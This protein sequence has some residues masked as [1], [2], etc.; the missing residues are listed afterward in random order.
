HGKKRP[1]DSNA[2]SSST[3]LNHPSSSRPLDDTI[4]ENDEESFHSN[5]SSTSQNVSSLSNAV[6]RVYQNPTHESQY[7]NTYLFETI[8]LQIQQRDAHREGLRSIGQALNDM[9]SEKHKNGIIAIYPNLDP[10]LDDFDKSDA[11]GDDWVDTLE[12]IDFGDIPNFKGVVV[13]PYVEADEEEATEEVIKG[14]KTLREKDSLEAFILHIHLEAKI[15]SFAL[16]DMGSNINVLSYQLYTNLVKPR[17]EKIDSEEE[18]DYSVK[19]DTNGK[20]FYGP[21]TSKYLNCDDPLDR[22]LALQGALNPFKMSHPQIGSRPIQ[23]LG[24]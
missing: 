3:T 2:S 19:R 9:M 23:R 13:P 1:R 5:S 8:N 11:S 14:Y 22:A 4:N 7:L 20:P 15:D 21:A 16:V 24:A 10:F 12:D 6:S 17:Q 18:K